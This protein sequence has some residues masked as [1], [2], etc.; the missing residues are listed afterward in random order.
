[1]SELDLKLIYER[2]SE[3]DKQLT[4]LRQEL[5]EFKWYQKHGTTGAV[6]YSTK[7]PIGITEEEWRESFK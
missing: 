4:Q 7:A 2:F 6:A 1:M 3:I 5:N